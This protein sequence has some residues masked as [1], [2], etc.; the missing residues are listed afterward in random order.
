MADVKCPECSKKFSK[1]DTPHEKIG[2][3][4]FHIP[5]AEKY[6][7]RK[8]S[9]EQLQ[10]EQRLVEK[11]RRDLLEYVAELQGVKFPDGLTMRVV[12]NLHEE[13]YTYKGIKATLQYFYEIEGNP[14]REDGN[15]LGIVP[16]V[17]N[18]A[19][20]YWVTI[21]NAWRV[22][23]EILKNNIPPLTKKKVRVKAQERKGYLDDKIIDIEK[24]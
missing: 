6:Y 2:N 18:K 10:A 19:K 24:L 13:G 9:E 20:A 1:E 22:N 5:C 3:R 15:V 17:Y 21:V 8:A 11:D 4:Y 14:V 7:Q 16:Y 23:D 12:K